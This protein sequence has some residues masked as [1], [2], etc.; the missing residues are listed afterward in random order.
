[1]ALF[2][3]SNAIAEGKTN[4]SDDTSFLIIIAQFDDI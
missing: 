2:D 4:R 1:V 3:R